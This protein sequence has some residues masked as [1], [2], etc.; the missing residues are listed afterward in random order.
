MKMSDTIEVGR[1][2][3]KLLID[4]MA[5]GSTVAKLMFDLKIVD[6][7]KRRN[8]AFGSVL[9]AQ[10]DAEY[11]AEQVS[12]RVYRSAMRELKFWY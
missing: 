10:Q 1:H 11:H 2:E 3:E 5:D 4:Y 12:A 6:I 9:K 8:A 7:L